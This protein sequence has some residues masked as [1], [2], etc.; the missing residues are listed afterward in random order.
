MPVGPYPTFGACVS[1]QMDIY[2]K[3][4]PNWTEDHLK[5]VAGGICYT[6]EQNM[7]QAAFGDAS[8]PDSCFAYV[9][10]EAKGPDG[11]KSLRSLPYKNADGSIDQDHLGNA[12]ARW[13]QTDIPQDKKLDVLKTLCN[14]AKSAGMDSELCAEHFSAGAAESFQYLAQI[15]SPYEYEGRFFTKIRLIDTSKSLPML[16]PRGIRARV[17]YE[18]LKNAIKRLLA[19][20][21]LPIVGPPEEGHNSI[22]QVGKPVQFN[23]PDGYADVTYEITDPKAKEGI[24]DGTWNA[25][26]PEMEARP[27][28][29]YVD[30]DGSHVLTDFD[31]DRVAFVDKGA[32]PA[33][34]VQGFWE[35][36]MMHQLRAELL[37]SH[38]LSP[39]GQSDLTNGAATRYGRQVADEN[40][41]I[42]GGIKLAPETDSPEIKKLKEEYE[43][44]LLLATNDKKTLEGEVAKLQQD[45]QILKASVG[46]PKEA[47]KEELDRVTGEVDKLKLWKAERLNAEIMDRVN[48]LVDLRIEAGFIDETGRL[49]EVERLKTLPTDALDTMINDAEVQYAHIKSEGPRAKYS[50]SLSSTV[51]D[52]WRQKLH[53]PYKEDVK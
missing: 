44:K 8:F 27:G 6:I 39:E 46:K 16:Y 32:Y 41:P 43:A 35:A 7:H 14:A 51:E 22:Q 45:A 31:F 34:A 53:M 4:H 10:E 29:W 12:L 11:A 42:N 5:E 33:S 25:V 38:T 17:T 3:K 9:P 37:Q 48:T 52:H 15:H 19:S 20:R 18:A 49:K 2:R 13:N 36:E 23:M 40:T 50:A 30:T 26:S 47:Y 28:K 21:N 24:R 1:A